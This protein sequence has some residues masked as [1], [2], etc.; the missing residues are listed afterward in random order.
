MSGRGLK[1]GSGAHHIN[2][3]LRPNPIVIVVNIT[4]GLFF[5]M[6]VVHIS[7]PGRLPGKDRPPHHCRLASVSMNFSSD[8]GFQPAVIIKSGAVIANTNTSF[9]RGG[10]EVLELLRTICNYTMTNVE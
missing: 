5:E 8:R 4:V 10:T 2:A 9:S 1:P 6:A 7:L 3:G